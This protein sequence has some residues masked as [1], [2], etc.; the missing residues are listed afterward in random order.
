MQIDQV[1]LADLN[2]FSAEENLSVFHYLNNCQTAG[3]KEQLKKFISKP[4]S[5][6]NKIKAN[7]ALLQFIA[8]NVA[9]WPTTI[10]NGCLMVIEKVLDQQIDAP[11][12]NPNAINAF[13]YKL[14]HKHDYSLLKF[15]AQQQVVF[16]QGLQQLVVKWQN[17]IIPNGG[18]QLIIEYIEQLL[19]DSGLQQIVDFE[20]PVKEYSPMQLLR[21]GAYCQKRY[22]NNL[23]QLVTHY[24]Q[25]EAWYALA[26]AINKYKLKFPNFIEAPNATLSAKG[27]FHILLPTPTAYDIDLAKENNFLFLTGA[28]MAGKSTLIKSVGVACYLAHLGMAVPAQEFSLTLLDGLLSNINVSD[29][30]VRGESYFYNEVQR[31]KNTVTKI[32]NGNKWLVLIDELFKGTNVQDAMRC[33]LAVIEG[34]VKIKPCVF[35]LS[36]HLYEISDSLKQY[37]NINFKYFETTLEQGQLKFSYQLKEGVSN[38]RLGYF[39]L[40]REGV[41]DLL[42]NI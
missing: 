16:L 27:L 33:S 9:A 18:L 7:Q 14:F 5:D 4:Y 36:T 34:L 19:N 2:I 22:R 11:P 40:Q 15:S 32:N 26:L 39:I 41:V 29:N 35:I 13:F 25:L 31:I 24:Y 20:K 37:P 10:T 30:I 1:S 8:N 38:D 28:N 3:G 21:V 12:E 23:L 42:N 6:L 17:Q